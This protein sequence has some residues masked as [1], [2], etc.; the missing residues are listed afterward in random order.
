MTP[1]KNNFVGARQAPTEKCGSELQVGVVL[2]GGMWRRGQKEQ[3][4]VNFG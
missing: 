3:E 4:G 2:G 1:S